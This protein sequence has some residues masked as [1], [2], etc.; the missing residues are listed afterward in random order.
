[1]DFFIPTQPL[2][3]DEKCWS[4]F[5]RDDL[6]PDGKSVRRVQ[7]IRVF[8]DARLVQFD[9]DLGDVAQFNHAA[10]FAIASLDQDSVGEAMDYADAMRGSRLQQD[11]RRVMDEHREQRD[12]VQL[13]IQSA[14]QMQTWIRQNPV[15]AYGLRGKA[16]GLVSA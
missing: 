5:E 4:L 15:R 1:M 11:L 9:R 12:V 7:G 8:R 10:P 14:E 13:A 6:T 2:R 16:R 3:R